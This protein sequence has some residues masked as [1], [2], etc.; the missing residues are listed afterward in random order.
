MITLSLLLAGSVFAKPKVWNP[1]KYGAKGDGVTINTK[2]I[3]Q[4]IDECADAGGGT[5][6]LRY[7]IYVSGTVRLRSNVTL[8]IDNNAVLRGSADIEDYPSITPKI[9]YLYR[10]RF[11]KYM[12][13]AESQTNICL[14]GTGVID[15]QG[16]L[17]H[18][19]KGDDGGRPYI[20]RFSE[21]K[22][23][24]VNSLMFVNSARWLSHYLACEDVEI[25][26]VSIRSRIRENRD[27]MDID[28]CN[29]VRISD[30]DIYSG[31]DA[32]VLKSTV[33]ELPCR[34]VTVT[35]CRLSGSPA[36]LKLGTESNGGFENITFSDCYLYDGRD[37]IAIEEVD[38]GICRNVTVSNIK[39]H[40]IEIPIF[41]RLGNRARPIPGGPTPGMGKMQ[42]VSISNV[43][44]SG[45]GMIGCSVTGIPGHRVEGV[46]LE[47]IRIKFA[48]GGTA[49]MAE[50][51]VPEKEKS[52][53][54]GWMFKELPA[55]GFYCRHVDGLNMKA[56][57]L[58]FE[59]EDA[60]PAIIAEDVQG[61]KIEGLKAQVKAGVE[62]V[63]ER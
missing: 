4:A 38:G 12:I 27:G 33:A 21:C 7:G 19:K 49:E 15:G 23:V 18:A 59:K 55:Y 40:N 5:V 58:S 52:Y 44:A 60:R 41:I 22:G 57:D 2:A 39:M 36:S 28:S 61:L 37:G 17:F 43:E 56:I 26:R 8:K 25:E 42:D 29:G 6:I 63:V 34:N 31:D 24:K 48:G 30:C 32:I 50:K 47:N 51:K 16:P 46:T 62:K 13:Y 35:N 53:P 14:T 1:C 3:Q 54:M 20:L 9:N 11:T 45:A 10:E